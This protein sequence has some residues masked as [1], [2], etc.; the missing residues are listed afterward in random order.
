MLFEDSLTDWGLIIL[1]DLSDLPVQ[2]LERC[3]NEMWFSSLVSPHDPYT[4]PYVF[5]RRA[6][7]V[8]AI[9]WPQAAPVE[10]LQGDSGFQQHTE[11]Y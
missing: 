1:D 8:S 9:T 7:C 2:S 5:L 6:V 3:Q 10:S 4:L 11:A